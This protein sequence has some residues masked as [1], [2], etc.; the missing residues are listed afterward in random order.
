MWSQQGPLEDQEETLQLRMW[1][2]KTRQAGWRGYT[3]T[4]VRD[5]VGRQSKNG[6]MV[7]L[8]VSLPRCI[9]PEAKRNVQRCSSAECGLSSSLWL[10]LLSQQQR[11]GRGLPEC[12]SASSQGG[13]QW[14]KGENKRDGGFMHSD[15]E[16]GT[17][18]ERREQ[19]PHLPQ[20]SGNQRW[21]I[22]Q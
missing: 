1:E 5:L 7:R 13:G 16:W 12:G 2:G 8:L 19:L 17:K 9:L 6:K 15:R 21:W 4:F 11:R 20:A 22:H 10:T 3:S 14:R 18:S